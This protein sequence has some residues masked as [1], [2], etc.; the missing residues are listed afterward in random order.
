[1]YLLANTLWLTKGNIAARMDKTRSGCHYNFGIMPIPVVVC[2]GDNTSASFVRQNL[3]YV[4]CSFDLTRHDQVKV[5]IE[6]GPSGLSLLSHSLCAQRGQPRG[7]HVRLNMI[8][9]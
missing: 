4:P 9:E 8:A 3:G 6:K 1:M 2:S 7:V 5:T